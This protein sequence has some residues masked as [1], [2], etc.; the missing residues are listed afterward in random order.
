MR[1]TGGGKQ[2]RFIWGWR[3]GRNLADQ[4]ELGKAAADIKDEISQEISV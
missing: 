4:V 3:L 2:V 1:K